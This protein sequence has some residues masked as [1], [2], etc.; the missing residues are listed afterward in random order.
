MRSLHNIESKNKDLIC[1]NEQ[2]TYVLKQKEDEFE[3]LQEKVNS[4]I[5]EN[6]SSQI[7]YER[8][9]TERIQLETQFSMV[10]KNLD[11]LSSE[12]R[13]LRND[14]ESYKMEISA[15]KEK[16]KRNRDGSVAA[17]GGKTPM[18]SFEHQKGRKQKQWLK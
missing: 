11:K 15:L 17:N 6:S 3:A 14:I 4:L 7:N 18:F 16:S 8:S 12:N 9:R 5:E 13:T 2:N 1:I 10:K